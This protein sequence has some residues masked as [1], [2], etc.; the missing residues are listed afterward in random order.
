MITEKI[1]VTVSAEWDGDG[2]ITPTAIHWADG[3]LY[4]IDRVLAVDQAASMRAGG[5]GLRYKV[6]LSCEEQGVFGK[7]RYL[8]LEKGLQPERWFVEGKTRD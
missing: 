6:R 4:T 8:F 5:F 1:Y 3:T 7:V 2:N